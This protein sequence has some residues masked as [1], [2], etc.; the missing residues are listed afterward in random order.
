MPVAADTRQ[1]A[2]RLSGRLEADEFAALMAPL[3]PWPGTGA[4]TPIA[5]AVSGGADSTSLALLV[6]EW[7]SPRG[8]RLLALVV[9]HGLRAGSGQEAAETIARLRSRGIPA[10]LLTLD[11]LQA[12]SSMAERA[13]IARYE[14]LTLACRD[15]GAIDL[16][17]GHHAGDQAET[18]LMRARAASGPDGLAGMA[19]LVETRDLRLVRPLLSVAPGRLRAVVEASGIGWIE[20]PSNRNPR[21]LRT[22]L[23]IELALSDAGVAHGL[24][25]GASARG[26]ERMTRQQNDAAVLAT[27]A[28]L[29]PEGFALLP[30]AL[31]S[32]RA[33]EALVRTVGGAA[34]RPRSHAIGAL[35]RRPHAVTLAGTRLMQSGRLGPGWLLLREAALIGPDLDAAD[36]VVWD[37]RYR[38]DAA[39]HAGTDLATVRVSALGADYLPLR[40]LSRLPA[41]VL[42]TLPV[43]RRERRLLAIPHLSWAVAPE[44]AGFRFRFQPPSPAAE[45]VVFTGV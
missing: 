2:A 12:G 39:R 26:V 27:A 37:G 16:L 9:D 4:A 1:D 31:L 20:D 25:D 15:V 40:A 17:L 18:V 36:G 10:R 13:R 41:A 24:L 21:A 11:G 44:W 34:Y 3:G 43:L 30:P 32:A 22:R 5:V 28:S 45:A 29:R 38:L 33:M 7:V 8:L 35:L 42:S 19:A 14:I 6:H 23:R